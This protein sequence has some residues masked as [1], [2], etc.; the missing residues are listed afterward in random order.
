MLKTITLT[1]A[2]RILE[3]G[4]AKGPKRTNLVKRNVSLGMNSFKYE[5]LNDAP[6]GK[7]FSR[8]E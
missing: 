7:P 6:P 5:S 1:A 2:K 4:P 8:D 3:Q